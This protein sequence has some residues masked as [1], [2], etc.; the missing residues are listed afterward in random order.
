MESELSGHHKLK[1]GIML[2]CEYAGCLKLIPST[3]FTYFQLLNA[4]W[5]EANEQ[6]SNVFVTRWLTQLVE[7]LLAV[8]KMKTD[9]S[10]LTGN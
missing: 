1:E 9:R 4:C 7:M 5:W 10:D 3:L 2:N 6:Q 8:F